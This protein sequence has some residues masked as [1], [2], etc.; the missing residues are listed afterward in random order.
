[1]VG[2]SDSVAIPRRFAGGGQAA[3]LICGNGIW[4]DAESLGLFACGQVVDC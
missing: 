4:I 1:M 2:F 3:A